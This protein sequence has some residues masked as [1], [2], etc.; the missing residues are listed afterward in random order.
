[1]IK[2]SILNTIERKLI[3]LLGDIFL[4]IIAL[5]LFGNN[6]LDFHSLYSFFS[7]SI[8]ISGLLLFLFIAYILDFYNL[9]KASKFNLVISQSLFISGIFVFIFFLLV[10]LI[11]DTGFWRIPLMVFLFGTPIQIFLWRLLYKD[12]FRFIPTIKKVLFIYDDANIENEKTNMHYINGNALVETYYQVKLTLNIKK[13]NINKKKKFKESLKKID[14]CV[15]SINDFN[16]LPIEIEKLI[17]E[18]IHS[19][20]EVQSYSSFYENIYEALPIQSHNNSFY[21]A[22]Q[23]KNRKIRYIHQLFTAITDYL[24]CVLIGL[25]LGLLIPFIFSINCFTNKGP[26]F[27]IQKRVGRFGEEFKI[28]KFRSMVVDAEKSGAKMATI[29]DARITAFGKILRKTRID[30]LPQII[31]VFK[32]DMSFI[33][34]RPER[35][36]FTD[37]LNNISPFYNTRHIVKPG[38]TG[39]AQ[40]KY[41]YGENLEDSIKKLEYD[42]FY[43]KNKSISLDIRII[44]K[45]ITTVLFSRG[46]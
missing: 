17:L 37:Q 7:L 41:K 28:Y 24:L 27:Y 45:T 3:L 38:I 6:A 21:E 31:S 20:K 1:M 4:I 22:L 14:A 5:N 43:I 15:L 32:G 13:N 36:F 35:K 44:F 30:E 39:W 46:T 34:P 23:L 9:E 8:I 26:L 33:G 19:G 12:T 25:F 18:L 29:G 2:A 11:L 16:D 42:L 10:V 40:V